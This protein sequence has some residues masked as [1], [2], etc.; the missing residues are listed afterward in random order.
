MARDEH[1]PGEE[2]LMTS[3][4][5]DLERHSAA[6]GADQ[7]TGVDGGVFW[8]HLPLFLGQ[9]FLPSLPFFTP[10]RRYA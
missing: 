6:L 8:V 7:L 4:L 2:T 5:D 3:L 1:L 10:F 9:D